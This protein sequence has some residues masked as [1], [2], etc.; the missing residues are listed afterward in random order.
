MA[1]VPSGH[2]PRMGN[3]AFH[4]IILHVVCHGEEPTE[5]VEEVL[6]AFGQFVRVSASHGEFT[7]Y[8]RLVVHVMVAQ[9]ERGLVTVV[10]G[11]MEDVDKIVVGFLGRDALIGI[12]VGIIAKKHHMAP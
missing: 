11:V 2:H 7:E 1:L 3:Q 4:P 9:Q 10:D 12:R 8:L 5:R 6:V